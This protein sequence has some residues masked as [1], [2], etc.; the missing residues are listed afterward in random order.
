MFSTLLEAMSVAELTA[1]LGDALET[2]TEADW[3]D[4]LIQAY[5]DAL[6]RKAPIADMPDARES[7][8]QL[9]KKLEGFAPETAPANPAAPRGPARLR[10][11]RGLAVL[12]A[13]ALAALLAVQAAGLDVLGAMARW[14]SEVFSLGSIR[15]KSAEDTPNDPPSPEDGAGVEYASLQEALDAYGVTE[16]SEPA[17]LP[18]GYVLQNI[19]VD[20]WPSGEFAGISVKYFNGVNILHIEIK[21]FQCT[22]T[23][24][25]E[26]TAD[27][28]DSFEI[29]GVTVYIFEN[30]NNITAAWNTEHYECYIGGTV[31]KSEIRAM[32]LSACSGQQ[33][34]Q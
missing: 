10:R 34:K 26:K 15:Y 21:T 20:C 8:A 7:Y 12:L 19:A 9:Q 2:M 28:V 11:R 13:A 14:T 22:P 33:Q 1:A 30:L 18:E 23:M 17:Q 32:A 31:A 27:S 25:L 16:I 24:Q 4:G 3:D 29:E 6:D 5:L